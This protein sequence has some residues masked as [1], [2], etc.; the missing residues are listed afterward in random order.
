MKQEHP[1][2][3]GAPSD[4]NRSDATQDRPDSTGSGPTSAVEGGTQEDRTAP[5]AKLGFGSFNGGLP[6]RRA[7]S[8]LLFRIAGGDT[9]DRYRILAGPLRRFSLDLPQPERASM[10]VGAYERHLTRQIRRFLGPGDCFV[11][12]GAHVGYMS[13]V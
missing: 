9:P 4:G 7:A 6:A 13:L 11:D 3:R 2:P 12:V 5:R 8:D 10:L 1:V